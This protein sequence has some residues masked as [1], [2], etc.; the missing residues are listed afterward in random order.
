MVIRAAAAFAALALLTSPAFAQ[1]ARGPSTTLTAADVFNLEHA[2]NP[3][4]SPDGSLIAYERVT[5]D[6][7][8]DRFRRSIWLVDEN[9]RAHRPMAQGAGDYTQP[10]WSPNGRAVAYVASEAGR[11]EL[12]VF[13]LDTQRS[14]TIARLAAGAANLTWSPDGA[15]LAFQMLAREAPSALPRLPSRPDGAQWGPTFN[16]YER[17]NYR[18]NGVGY[19]PNGYS[20]IFVTP[21]DGG[22]PRQLT[23]GR[24]E[25]NGRMSWSADGRRLIYSANAEEGW[26]AQFVESDVYSLN[27]ADG[28]I[29]RLTSRDGRED[30][31][32][33]SPDG[34]RMA[35]VGFDDRQQGYQVTELYVANADG[36]NPRSLTGSFDRDIGNPQWAGNGSIYFLFVDRGQTKLGRVSASGGAVTTVLDNVGSAGLGRPGTTGAYTI[37]SSGRYAVT[38]G[39]SQRPADVSIGSGGNARRL[40]SLN[41]DLLA[42][43]TI[44]QATRITVASSADGRPVDGWI[45]RPPNFDPSRRYPMVLEI[46]G[47]PFAAYGPSFSTEFQLYAAA[48][49]IVVYS[50][51]R[52]STSYGSEFGNLI[53]HAYPSQDYDDLMS[54]VDGAIAQE[55]IDTE[56]LYVTGASGGGVLTAWIVGKT[57]RFRAALSEAPVINWTSFNLYTDV[58]VLANDYWFGEPVWAEGAVNRYWARSPLSLVG[59]VQT[60]TALMVGEADYRTPRSEA[61]QFHRALLMRGIPTRLI[62][63]P[64]ASHTIAARPTGLA[65]KIS[66]AL[67]WFAQFGG[68]PVPDPDTGEQRAA[69]N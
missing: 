4:I 1:P 7:M 37:T 69:A 15:T 67:A 56:R 22:A 5:G 63:V 29:R 16:V 24:A 11:N 68:P 25:L 66:A 33:L 48:G 38:T 40:T 47:G 9:G 26:E 62:T 21:A 49:Y 36:S 57:N 53:H 3:R 52:G 44:P 28:A 46:H 19:L 2:A 59:N 8:V 12:R 17:N 13:Y 20:Q 10:V 35:Y 55:P 61:E 18:A 39:T 60:P 64:E 42:T 58:N 6:I 32:T 45:I 14:A 65:A 51:P 27:V 43:K 50:N 23:F 54:I 31:P 30:T 34:R 41:D